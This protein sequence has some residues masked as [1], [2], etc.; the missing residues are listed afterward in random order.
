MT[1]ELDEGE[2]EVGGKIMKRQRGGK[3]KWRRGKGKEGSSEEPA[4][5][6]KRR[7]EGWSRKGGEE[8]K[9]ARDRKEK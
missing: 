3:E 9:Q 4:S 8:G 7:K 6:A 5:G 1:V 2:R